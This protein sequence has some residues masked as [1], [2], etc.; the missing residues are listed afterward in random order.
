MSPL[1]SHISVP[2]GSMCNSSDRLCHL[3]N[4]SRSSLDAP[5]GQLCRDRR[6]KGAEEEDSRAVKQKQVERLEVSP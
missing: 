1:E 2:F 4:L 5:L 6:R 3:F